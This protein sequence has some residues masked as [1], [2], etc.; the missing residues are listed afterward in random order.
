VGASTVLD[1]I[2]GSA[3][4]ATVLLAWLGTLLIDKMHTDA[5]FQRE[6]KRRELVEAA[7][8]EKDKTIAEA[9]ARADAA[10]NALERM[11]DAIASPAR[12][13]KG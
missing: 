4:A 11:A 10:V 12:R 1:I 2:N 8:L 3:G 5:E 13:S 6:V 7:N 9:N